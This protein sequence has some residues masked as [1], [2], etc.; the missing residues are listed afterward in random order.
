MVPGNVTTDTSGHSR[1]IGEFVNHELSLQGTKSIWSRSVVL[2]LPG[3]GERETCSNL[4][5][6]GEV[7]SARA[8]FVGDVSG[9]VH[10]RQNERE[11]TV[12]FSNLF[13]VGEDYRSSSKHDWR[14]L[15]SDI[16]DR[17]SSRSCH[18][19]T[20]LLDPDDTSDTE[21]SAE[22]HQKCKIGDLV[23]KHGQLLIGAQNNR[24]CPMTILM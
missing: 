15:V 20:T 10:F 18:Y 24:Y 3:K 14:L 4:L 12:V 6:V 16:Y 21:C 9:E 17:N 1:L 13:Y 2:R 19:L 23:R 11:E 7:H 5:D 22:D 8:L